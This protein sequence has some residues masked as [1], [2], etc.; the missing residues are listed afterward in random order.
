MRHSVLYKHELAI[1]KCQFPEGVAETV[2]YIFYVNGHLV[3]QV[4]PVPLVQ[5]QD[6]GC[7][8]QLVPLG[9]LPI[10]SL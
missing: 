2:T 4:L 10:L 5:S 1:F 3:Y 7:H 6:C 8:M 9:P